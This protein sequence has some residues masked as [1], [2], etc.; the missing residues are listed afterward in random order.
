M[1]LSSEDQIPVA[2]QRHAIKSGLGMPRILYETGRTHLITRLTVVVGPLALLIGIGIVGSY[3]YF[4][5]DVFSWWPLWQQYGMLGLGWAWLL[6][7]LWIS[8][9]PI[10]SPPLLVYLCPKGMIY[11]PRRIRT[12]YWSKIHQINRQLYLDKKAHLHCSY[13]LNCIDGSQILLP[14]SLPYLDRLISFIEREQLRRVLPRLLNEYR[15]G[16]P[17]EFGPL[18]IARAGIIIQANGDEP[19]RT[20]PWKD[21]AGLSIDKA[22]VSIY[23]NGDS[24][25]WAT[26]DIARV[27]NVALLKGLVDNIIETLHKPLRRQ[28]HKQPAP[29]LEA[30]EAGYVVSFGRLSISKAGVTINNGEEMLPWSEI[31]SIGVGETEV[32]IH[33]HRPLEVKPDNWYA[34]PLWGITD[35]PALREIVHHILVHL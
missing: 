17:S 18:C 30:Y 31:A 20:L 16:N 7:G 23:R 11:Q 22:T 25:E 28:P 15:A 24:W 27:S 8:L 26:I 32:I 29:H 2:I 1:R 5:N 14:S 6:V 19:Q 12:I 10:L 21:V 4:F 13:H 33:R 34:V 3:N 9:T 35:V